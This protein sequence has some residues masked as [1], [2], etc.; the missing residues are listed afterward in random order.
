VRKVSDVIG[1]DTYDGGGEDAGVKIHRMSAW[2]DRVGVSRLGIG[3]FNG[4]SAAAITHA[5]DAVKSDHRFVWACV[6]GTA[7]RAS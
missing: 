3:E 2:A 7:P 6:S 1:A 5:T 4:Q